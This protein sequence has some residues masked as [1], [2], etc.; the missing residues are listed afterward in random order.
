MS[1]MKYRTRHQLRNDRADA[2]RRPTSLDELVEVRDTMRAVF[3]PDPEA[4]DPK[5]RASYLLNETLTR[6]AQRQETP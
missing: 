1:R 6:R 4:M 3:G 5:P 2:L